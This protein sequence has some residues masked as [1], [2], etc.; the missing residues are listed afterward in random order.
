M[1][2]PYGIHLGVSERRLVTAS[3]WWEP[4]FRVESSRFLFTGYVNL[5]ASQTAIV[6]ISVFFYAQA[7]Q[8]LLG[9]DVEHEVMSLPVMTL[10]SWLAFPKC[11]FCFGNGEL[12][13]ST[14]SI[15][16]GG[17]NKIETV[18]V[19]ELNTY[20][21]NSKPQ[22]P[23][24]D[25]HLGC[26]RLGVYK[27]ESSIFVTGLSIYTVPVEICEK[28]AIPEAEWPRAIGELCGKLEKGKGYG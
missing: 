28:L 16:Y 7:N 18:T 3:L 27:R 13:S 22:V 2:D 15:K 20:V 11:N 14:S 4:S 8:K 1:R 12:A 9:V 10:S 19:S 17:V 25:D 24:G 5:E 23:W 6:G 26:D 21:V